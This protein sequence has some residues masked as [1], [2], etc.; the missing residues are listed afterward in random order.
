M[1]FLNIGNYKKKLN[2][3]VNGS[4]NILRKSCDKEI[5]YS[6]KIFN[7]MKIKNIN[8]LHDVVY[9]NW[10]LM[11]IGCVFQPNDVYIK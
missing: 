1:I 3:D 11:D 4:L 10:Q 8:E 2:A 6:N 9:F 7:P 5:T